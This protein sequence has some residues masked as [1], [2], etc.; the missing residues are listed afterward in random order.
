[1][2]SPVQRGFWWSHVGW[3]L[4]PDYDETELSIASP[5]SRSIPSCAG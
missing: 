5:T 1:M 2:H 3:I 4:A